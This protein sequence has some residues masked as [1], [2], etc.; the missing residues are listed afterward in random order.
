MVK[1]SRQER[2]EAGLQ[3]NSIPRR[4][5]RGILPIVQMR[6]PVQA[7]LLLAML[8][9]SCSAI[10]DIGELVGRDADAGDVLDGDIRPEADVPDADADGDDGGGDVPPDSTDVDTPDV[11]DVLGDG[12]AS[13]DGS[14]VDSFEVTDETGDGPDAGEIDDGD[15]TDVAEADALDVPGDDS[16][17]VGPPA[18]FWGE[19]TTS[20]VP[21]D[22]AGCTASGAGLCLRSDTTDSSALELSGGAFRLRGIV[23]GGGS[24]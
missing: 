18:R 15:T 23:V 9:P 22:P 19:L 12:D 17:T 2:R 1:L 8:T 10:V 16:G 14:D 13:P 7:A 5:R 6:L 24:P 20:G 3:E 4:C 21:A 11:T